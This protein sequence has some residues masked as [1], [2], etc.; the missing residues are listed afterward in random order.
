M[1]YIV[2]EHTIFNTDIGVTDFLPLQDVLE[3]DYFIIQIATQDN[4][5][6][7]LV[8]DTGW[9][10][11]SGGSPTGGNVEILFWWKKVASDG[12]TPTGIENIGADNTWANI[13][14]VRGLDLTDPIDDSDGTYLSISDTAICPAVTS[15]QAN[16]IVLRC[17]IS[18]GQNIARPKTLM[19]V[20]F[21]TDAY[22]G[23]NKI[24]A[25][26][27][28]TLEVSLAAADQ[29]AASTVVLKRASGDTSAPIVT[30]D[31]LGGFDTLELK[32]G[33]THN[34]GEWRQQV[35]DSGKCLDYT[36]G[37]ET[38]TVDMSKTWSGGA[39]IV[40]V[41]GVSGGTF[42]I[43]NYLRFNTGLYRGEIVDIYDPVGATVYLYLKAP[44]GTIPIN[45]E[46]CTE[47]TDVTYGTPTGVTGLAQGG[48]LDG[49]IGVN[50]FRVSD[51]VTYGRMVYVTNMTAFG[52]SDGY[53]WLGPG[54]FG[55]NS[56]TLGRY[57]RLSVDNHAFDLSTIKTLTPEAT[58]TANVTD[59][60]MVINDYSESGDFD[61]PFISGTPHYWNAN[62]VGNNRVFTTAQDLSDELMAVFWKPNSTSHI[63][64][65]YFWACDDDGSW[66]IWKINQATLLLQDYFNL[67]AFD[68]TETAINFSGTFDATSIKYYAILYQG[69]SSGSRYGVDT[70]SQYKINDMAVS[71]GGQS[72]PMEMWQI[73]K[74]LGKTTIETGAIFADYIQSYV[75]SQFI[76]ANT[77]ILGDGS[78]DSYIDV[79]NAAL[80][81]LPQANGVSE[82]QFNADGN[83]IGIEVDKCGG[84]I[85]TDLISSDSG[86]Y[87]TGTSEDTIDYN[88][89]LLIKALPTLQSGK[90]YSGV[91]FVE[92]GQIAKN[93]ASLAGCNVSSSPDANGALFIDLAVGGT[94]DTIAFSG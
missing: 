29:W 13:M 85:T 30:G 63:R 20:D 94:L 58:G 80:S 43:G 72:V 35:F 67:V 62:I 56:D 84:S 55:L 86:W 3:N 34:G 92:C 33:I 9:T 6:V 27:S 46:P 37:R 77:L 12:E 7:F 53:Y 21:A 42:A 68:S 89:T 45:N 25:E 87:F 17:V 59:V 51:L 88:G 36:G 44:T 71:G 16:Q 66:K 47:Y 39:T 54:E 38:W 19:T 75:P 91:S 83:K 18:D 69:A 73:K 10:K 11:D 28:G 65:V 14:V 22:W 32:T 31:G 15:T 5:E 61:Y 40:Q 24:D 74:W 79:T 4:N 1:S 93:A 60:G 52:V 78:F 41:D 57:R 76:V 50:D 23:F 70:Y 8:D 81:T 82:V 26:S 2:D 49:T 90:T 64:N 48:G